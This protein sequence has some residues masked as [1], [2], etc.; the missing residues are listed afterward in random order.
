[1]R[2]VV[3]GLTLFVMCAIVHADSAPFEIGPWK[4]IYQPPQRDGESWWINDHSFAQ[5]AQ[6]DW[7]L[8]GIT[9]PQP[10]NPR[11]ATLFDDQALAR[12]QPN[13]RL[14]MLQWAQELRQG[15]SPINTAKERQ[16]AHARSLGSIEGK[17]WETLPFSLHAQNAIGETLLWA[18]HVVHWEGRYYKFYSG[19]GDDRTRFGMRLAISDDLMNWQRPTQTPLFNDGYEARDPM[20]LRH[21]TQWIMYYTATL[22]PKGGNHI[23]AYRLSSDLLNWGERQ[24]AFTDPREGTGGGPTESPFVVE[25]NDKF[26][27]FLA[28]RHG[29]IPGYYRDT[30]VFMSDNPYHWD[31]TNP[32][33]RVSAH[34]AELF[35]S[36][37]N[38]W[39]ISHSGWYQGGVYVAPLH[40][41]D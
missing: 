33:A 2:S 28:M 16:F 30:E 31:A 38:Q 22:D 11:L 3:A 32:V 10:H 17:Q 5:D 41:L 26:Y 20:V 29:Y 15:P 36:N 34:A 1:M 40:W 35:R 13:E 19:G 4:R 27:L 37:D 21:G 23:V 9:A 25:H 39:Y 12:M 14:D 6:G 18:P 7:H 8:F 24:V